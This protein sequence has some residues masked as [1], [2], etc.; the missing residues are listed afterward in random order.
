MYLFSSPSSSQCQ[1]IPSIKYDA[2][3][4][5]KLSDTTLFLQGSHSS[6]PYQ[7]HLYKHT[8]GNLSPDWSL[9]LAWP[10]GTWLQN[11]SESMRISS[12]IYS[13]ISYGSTQYVYMVVISI[14]DGS[15][16]SRYK[17]S[18]S[19]APVWGS[20]TN[21][22]YVVASIHCTTPCLLLFNRSTNIFTIK[23]FSG[24]DLYGMGIEP[25]TNR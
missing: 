11:Y 18:I 10:S 19:W 2:F 5:L 8:F 7:L 3:G 1:Q 6:S 14:S 9:K 23:P 17:S 21:E 12:L 15:V 25:V 13:F 4:Q 22:D 20:G 16:S 24:T